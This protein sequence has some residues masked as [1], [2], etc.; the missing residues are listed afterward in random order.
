M[1]LKDDGSEHRLTGKSGLEIK[2]HRCGCV[3]PLLHPHIML[4]RTDGD[5]N[6]ICEECY[7]RYKLECEGGGGRC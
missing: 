6:L 5:E 3:L 4:E 2:C 1:N 7:E